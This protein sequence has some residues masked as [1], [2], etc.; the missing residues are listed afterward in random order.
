MMAKTVIAKSSLVL[1]ASAL[2]VGAASARERVWRCTDGQG[3]TVY[4]DSACAGSLQARAVDAADPR[5]PDQVAAARSRAQSEQALANTLASQRQQAEREAAARPPVHLAG[6]SAAAASAANAA[7]ARERDRK[8][9]QERD[10]DR[11]R[12]RDRDRKPRT[13]AS[14]D[15]RNGARPDLNPPPGPPKPR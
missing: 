5:D 3:R 2:I 15:D 11:D 4:Q 12:E 7:I 6:P 10:H 9:A 14:N 8:R 1:L 13:T